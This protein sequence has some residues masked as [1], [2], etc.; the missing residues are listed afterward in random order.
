[1]N[2]TIRIGAPACLL[3]FALWTA[4]LAE[5]AQPTQTPP[6]NCQHTN[7]IPTSDGMAWGQTLLQGGTILYP[8]SRQPIGPYDPD[9]PYIVSNNTR[10]FDVVGSCCVQDLN[11]K[12]EWELT[13]ASQGL[14]A[15]LVPNIGCPPDNTHFLPQCGVSYVIPAS[16][17]YGGA[18]LKMSVWNY[19]PSAYTG[20]TCPINEGKGQTF[21]SIVK[22][23]GIV[24]PPNHTLDY[25]GNETIT[26]QVKPDD[27]WVSTSFVWWA[28]YKYRFSINGTPAFLKNEPV[29]TVSELKTVFPEFT[30]DNIE[31]KMEAAGDKDPS[32]QTQWI[33]TNDVT[34]V[35]FLKSKLKE[36]TYSG[37]NHPIFQ[38]NGTL[39][40]IPHWKDANDDGD[41]DDE[42][43]DGNGIK[44]HK[45]PVA[46]TKNTKP[47]LSAIFE[48]APNDGLTSVKIRGKLNGQLYIPETIVP[49][50]NGVFVLPATEALSAFK[51]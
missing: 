3:V 38:D 21:Q 34:N 4:A 40:G 2:R 20:I 27:T 45:F 26:F 1:M 41:A 30:T 23:I 17:S 11:L 10:D 18:T 49:K 42:Y 46:Y 36:V 33:Q 14:S 12:L 13:G 28:G 35:I 22:F 50:D 24:A 9:F 37:G 7:S 5:T 43:T 31:I 15:Y 29:L 51:D 6:P 16:A 39:Y 48:I 8:G 44:E 32:Y 47:R 19:P 25:N